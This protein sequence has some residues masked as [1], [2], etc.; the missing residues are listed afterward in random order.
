MLRATIRLPA[1]ADIAT[2]PPAATVAD[3]LRRQL[4]ASIVVKVVD[5]RVIH[6]DASMLDDPDDYDGSIFADLCTTYPDE[7]GQ[8]YLDDV[9]RVEETEDTSGATGTVN[10]DNPEDG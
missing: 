8:W 7:D 4:A 2:N 5:P 6:V 3:A 9:A 1:Y 10:E